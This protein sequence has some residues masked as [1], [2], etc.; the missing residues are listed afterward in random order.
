MRSPMA[1]A[2]AV[3]VWLFPI[4][5]Y[6]V[7]DALMASGYEGQQAEAIIDSAESPADAWADAMARIRQVAYVSPANVAD[8]E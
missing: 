5:R 6:A 2:R 4:P 8:S 3:K 7:K 1:P